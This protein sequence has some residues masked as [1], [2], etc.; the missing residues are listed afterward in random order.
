MLIN[1]NRKCKIFFLLQINMPLYVSYA[2]CAQKE[3]QIFNPR[4]SNCRFK[5]YINWVWI[6][7]KRDSTM[8]K[9][10]VYGLKHDKSISQKTK[11]N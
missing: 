6:V 4:D 2:Y 5:D 7:N 11:N 1:G 8:A 9:S 3:R 10:R